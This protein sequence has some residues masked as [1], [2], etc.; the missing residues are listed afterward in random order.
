MKRLNNHLPSKALSTVP[1]PFLPEDS[2]RKQPKQ[3][4]MAFSSSTTS[5]HQPISA[6]LTLQTK[7]PFHLSLS[8]HS[9]SLHSGPGRRWRWTHSLCLQWGLEHGPGPTSFFGGTKNQWTLIF[10]TLLT[11][12]LIWYQS[13]WYTADSYGTGR[14]NGQSEKLLGKFLQEFPGWYVFLVPF[15]H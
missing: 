3:S 11:W 1:L 6:V 10:N 15:V 2:A 12:L 14:L 9:N 5:Y 13:F 7:L 8:S 4:N